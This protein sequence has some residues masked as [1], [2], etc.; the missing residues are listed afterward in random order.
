MTYISATKHFVFDGINYDC[1]RKMRTNQL[2]VWI[3]GRHQ[4]NSEI[5]KWMKRIK[6]LT[7]KFSSRQHLSISLLI[8]TEW[9]KYYS[10]LIIIY[11]WTYFYISIGLHIQ[12]FQNVEFVAR[13]RRHRCGEQKSIYG[14]L[15]ILY[16]NKTK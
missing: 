4:R 13:I 3:S 16:P 2:C 7:W 12:Y 10:C 8:S 14:S 1:F 6:L 15:N 5:A 11:S 9:G